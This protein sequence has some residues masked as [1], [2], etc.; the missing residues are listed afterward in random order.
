MNKP[1]ALAAQLRGAVP[2][3][4]SQSTQVEQSRA[5][6]EVQAMAVLAKQT[7]RDE[8]RAIAK[9]QE[10]CG[11]MGLAERAFFKFPRG[12]QT[13]SGKS[14]HLATE[15]ARC[16]GNISY[17]VAELAR[18]HALGQSEMVAYAWDMETNARAATAF[19]V[20]HM[21]D[22]K[23]GVEPLVDMRDIYENNANNA[24]RRLREMIFRVLPSWY[25]EEA[26]E[27]CHKTLQAGSSTKPFPQQVAECLKAFA[28][29]GISRDRIEAKIGGKADAMTP[30]DLAN[31]R[32]S[33]TSIKR[34][35]ISAE[36]EFPT[37]H[38]EELSQQLKADTPPPP[39]P[40]PAAAA[41][42]PD[43][44][45]DADTG[46]VVED[47]D[48]GMFIAVPMTADGRNS[49]WQA[50]VSLFEAKLPDPDDALREEFIEAN[51]GPLT[52]FK[53]AMPKAYASVC[54]RLGLQ[55]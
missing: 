29:I 9:M 20:P 35:E 14:I 50:W 12:G 26:A 43:R 8:T 34:S 42:E 31:L 46:E 52:G 2:V 25:A 55:V 38:A 44:H 1:V 53:E 39:A 11:R 33:Y 28:D 40:K 23:N 47:G 6:A 48:G 54:K 7:P 4:A 21:R 18:D 36:D 17:G 16:W 10:A 22:K 27:I 41:A 3:P 37:K 30:V 19:I 24:A 13:V 49:D 5:V 45:Y 32:V 51:R 15:L